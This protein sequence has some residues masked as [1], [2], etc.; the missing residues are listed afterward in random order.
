MLKP[1]KNYEDILKKKIRDTWYDE[2]YQ[3]YHSDSYRGDQRFDDDNRWYFA[4]IDE[5]DNVIGYISFWVSRDVN[6]VCSWGAISFDIGNL[7][8]TKD[9][10]QLVDDLFTKYRFNRIEWCCVSGN[11]ILPSYA[12]FAARHGGRQVGV[13]RETVRTIDGELRNC[14]TFEILAKDYK[15]R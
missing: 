11:P 1:A 8:F 12:R 13:S 2:R 10:I 15:R 3:W 9:L 14:H 7:T 5:N 6:Q 4:S